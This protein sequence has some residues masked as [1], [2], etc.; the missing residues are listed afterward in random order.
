MDAGVQNEVTSD[1]KLWAM[2]SYVVPLIVPL[3]L[4]VWE[5]KRSRPFIHSHHIQSLV[6]GVLWGVSLALATGL[7]GCCTTPIIYIY[8]VYL[9]VQAYQ[10]KMVTIPVITD[11]VKNQGWA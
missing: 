7:I 9:G 11:F 5:E 3:V 6:L 10:G 4:F 1:D 2:L 8:M